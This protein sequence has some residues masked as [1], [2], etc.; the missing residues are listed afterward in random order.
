MLKQAIDSYILKFLKHNTSVFGL[1]AGQRDEGIGMIFF[2]IFAVSLSFYSY[3]AKVIA[4]G[5]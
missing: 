5:Y 2:I 4:V 3:L 1:E